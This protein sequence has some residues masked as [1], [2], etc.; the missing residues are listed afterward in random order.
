VTPFAGDLVAP[1]VELSVYDNASAYTCSENHAKDDEG[2][3]S[4]PIDGLRKCEAI[5][6]ILHAYRPSQ[7]ALKIAVERLAV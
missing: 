7:P 1:D 4:R 6:V 3:R 5:R 2:F